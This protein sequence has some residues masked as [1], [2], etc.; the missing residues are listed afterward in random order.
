MFCV[1]FTCHRCTVGHLV[2]W[3][4]KK[5]SLGTFSCFIRMFW[6]TTS[7]WWKGSGCWAWREWSIAWFERDSQL[8]FN[9]VLCILW[10][11][12]VIEDFVCSSL[13]S[14]HP[15]NY[16]AVSMFNRV[17][18]FL[19]HLHVLLTFHLS[20]RPRSFQT[21]MCW[22][23]CVLV[24]CLSSGHCS[25]VDVAASHVEMFKTKDAVRMNGFNPYLPMYTKEISGCHF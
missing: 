23:V 21:L 13:L 4:R 19:L 24:C 9:F 20:L 2:N 17:S 12:L 10:F 22:D 1:S 3:T 5:V 18:G 16:P 6:T 11:C 15:P 8:T 7:F 25:L 14:I